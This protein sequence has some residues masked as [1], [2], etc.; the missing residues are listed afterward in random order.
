MSDHNAGGPANP[1][2]SQNQN[3][4]QN[5]GSGEAYDW[6][7]VLEAPERRAKRA[8]DRSGR[9]EGPRRL[10]VL[11]W[12]MVATCLVILAGGAT[13]AWM[14]W[15][16]QVEAQRKAADAQG[17]VPVSR[18]FAPGQPRPA[19]VLFRLA[20]SSHLGEQLMPDLAAAWMRARGWSGVGRAEDGRVVVVS[21]T[22]D[23]KQG[24]ILIVRG[25]AHGGF[26]GLMQGRVEAVVS[27]RRILPAEADRLSALGDM[28]NPSSEKVIALDASLV[29]VNRA[30]PLNAIN[31]ETLGRILSGEV[32][33]WSEVFANGDGQ[34]NV[35][36]ENLGA[37]LAASP[38][39]RLL[40]DEEP[41]QNV[42]LLDTSRAVADAV[43]RDGSAIGIARRA[44]AGGGAKALSLN[45]RNAR[46]VGPDDFAIATEAYPFTE[47]VHLYVPA[48]GDVALVRDFGA[49]ALSPVGQEIVARVGLT[50]QKA[51][52]VQIVPPPEA[53][54]EYAAFARDARRMN[55]DIRF[56]L[57]S[58]KLDS[59]AVED[60]R[61]LSAYL[62]ANSIDE[63]RIALL[64]FADNVGA[65]ATN[66]GL[67]QT[68][69]ETVGIELERA[70]INPG[71][72]R[73]YG[74]AM[75]V[76][77]NAE[78]RGRIR[79]RRVEIWLCA[80][81]ACPLVDLVA[82]ARANTREIPT[83]VRLGPP[84]ATPAGVD[85]PKG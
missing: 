28:T 14:G 47:R 29:L 71:I 33:N 45:E 72:I 17:L 18:D 54:R 59:K 9:R 31:S 65:R 43:G 5:Q 75:P 38:A 82:S 11:G 48:A 74:D 61:R 13:L 49:Y 79:N 7:K 78:E 69:A 35:K 84:P 62:Q 30:N 42:T 16:F 40:G 56:D 68:R 32:T 50:P 26:E 36:L 46:S 6:N 20:G 39:G 57:G 83:G 67:A 63:R 73:S 55:F 19:D 51:D 12:A 64:G 4:S 77:A 15:T 85:P 58:N 34:I 10:S 24:R 22:K 25:S 1:S 53:T 21:G 23:G 60:V 70:G 3:Q 27:A 52:A 66:A 8:P 2:Q 41:P 80:P 44:D 81:P 37:D 76:G